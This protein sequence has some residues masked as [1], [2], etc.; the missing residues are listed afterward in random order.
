MCA[1]ADAAVEQV[2]WEKVIHAEGVPIPDWQAS[3]CAQCR[4]YMWGESSSDG[5]VVRKQQQN[6]TTVGAPACQPSLGQT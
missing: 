3:T 4:T 1:R 2:G 6:Q 5:S